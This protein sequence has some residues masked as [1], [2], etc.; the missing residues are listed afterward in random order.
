VVVM[1]GK[2]IIGSSNA[3]GT[4]AEMRPGASCSGGEPAR[5]KVLG[6]CR[7]TGLSEFSNGG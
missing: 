6:K 1:E 7:A 4:C 5:G 3:H 2:G